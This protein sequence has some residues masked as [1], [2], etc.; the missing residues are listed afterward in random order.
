MGGGDDGYNYFGDDVDEVDIP[1]A[2][3][4][5][6]STMDSVDKRSASHNFPY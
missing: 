1:K 5:W 6:K 2:A 4:K 3:E